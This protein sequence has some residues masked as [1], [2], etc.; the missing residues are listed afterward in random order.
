MNIIGKTKRFLVI[1]VVVVVSFFVARND[2]QSVLNMLFINIL[3][4]IQEKITD[5][6]SWTKKQ[7]DMFTNLTSSFAENQRLKNELS[8]LREKN[9]SAVEVWAENQ[10]LRGLLDYKQKNAR[11]S[12]VTAKVIGRSPARMHN[13]IIINRGSAQGI[14]ENMPVV[15]ADGLVGMVSMVYADVAKV[16]LLTSPEAAVGAIV[17]RPASRSIGLVSGEPMEGAYLKLSKLSRDMEISVGDVVVTSGLSGLYPKG[18]FIGEVVEVANAKD[19]LLKYAML[20]TRASFDRLE[21]V[22]VLTNAASLPDVTP[23]E[24]LNQLNKPPTPVKPPT[25]TQHTQPAAAPGNAPTPP[26]NNTGAVR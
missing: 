9:L 18:I 2:T 24:I 21:E 16:T 4:P 5:A 7:K 13:E 25:G 10:R 11:M 14:R 19:G 20:K 23:P 8:D 26:V 17:Q 6:G 3:S 1:F 12:L 22:M 15:N